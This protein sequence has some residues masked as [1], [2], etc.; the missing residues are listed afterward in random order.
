MILV[1][2]EYLPSVNYFKIFSNNEIT[3]NYD[4]KFSDNPFF[5]RSRLVGDTGVFD[6]KIPTVANSSAYL[7]DI[8]I[9]YSKNWINSHIQSIQSAYGK[10]PYY[11]YY[12]DHIIN[13]IK[14]R[15]NFLI[16][17]NCDLLTLF[18]D[19]L[20]FENKIFK[21]DSKNQKNFQKTVKKSKNIKI[22]SFAIKEFRNN[23]F[24]GKKFDYPVSV[25]DLLFLKGPESGYFINNY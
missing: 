4:V 7:R 6:I 13:K 1:E 21:Y 20:N 24:L 10:Y 8:K 5:N 14:L 15:H 9:D 12:K 25:L 22:S 11:I 19:L 17:L 18:C 2:P 3:I 23:F 16:D